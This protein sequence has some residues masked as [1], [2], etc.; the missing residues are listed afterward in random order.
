LEEFNLQEKNAE[1]QLAYDCESSTAD[2]AS[3]YINYKR[4]SSDVGPGSFDL[5]VESKNGSTM[6][7]PIIAQFSVL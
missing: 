3:A 2:G 4:R 7:D 1:I 5:G 6:V